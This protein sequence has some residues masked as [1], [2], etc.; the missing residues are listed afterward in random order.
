MSIEYLFAFFF[1]FLNQWRKCFCCTVYVN[2][3]SG[4]FLI[5]YD[6]VVCLLSKNIPATVLDTLSSLLDLGVSGRRRFNFGGITAVFRN[7][8]S[9][10][11]LDKASRLRNEYEQK[12][13]NTSLYGERRGLKGHYLANCKKID[14]SHTFWKQNSR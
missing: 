9:F 8:I 6:L 3:T 10:N 1:S 12:L 11:P 4:F 5:R 14:N 7:I 13:K 2:D